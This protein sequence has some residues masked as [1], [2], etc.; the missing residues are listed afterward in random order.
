MNAAR[1]QVFASLLQARHWRWLPFLV[2]PMLL[3]P[4]CFAG[5]EGLGAGATALAVTG[6]AALQFVWWSLF[7]RLLRQNHPNT[8][9]LVPGQ[10][11]KLRECGVA[12][13]LLNA[14][15]GGLLMGAARG[16]GL[17]WFIVAAALQ[18]LFAVV[19]R[20]PQLWL[21]IWVPLG[22]IGAMRDS[23]PGLW[24]DHGL[25]AWHRAEPLSQALI[26]GL[27]MCW[28]LA[29]LMFDGGAA[30]E[31]QWRMLSA[32]RA[33]TWST[34]AAL[35]LSSRTEGACGVWL[36]R[37]FNWPFNPWL[38]HLMRSA[39]PTPDSVMARAELV[40]LRNSHWTQQLGVISVMS[41]CVMLV[42]LFLA[43][44]I[45]F[46][47]A[48]VEGMVTGLSL[49]LMN[50]CVSPVFGLSASLYASRREQALLMLL[51]GMP[52][53][54][55]LNKRLARRQLAQFVAW[56]TAGV[57]MLVLV[58]KLFGTDTP[59]YGYAPAA[60]LLAP[61]QWRDWSRQPS[62]RSRDVWLP[63]L[64]LALG[65]LMARW[66]L[67]TAHWPALDFALLCAGMA[68]ALAFWR[69]RRIARWPQAF[70][71]GRLA[72]SAS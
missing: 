30:H 44:R 21:M 46:N 31:R 36:R 11:R 41:A 50:M 27:L 70:P 55:A 3:I 47:K 54:S 62:P 17:A 23:A 52:R 37:S 25:R 39:R 12:V 68:L 14:A 20:W 33:D 24:L 35:G 8:A 10:L 2:L 43:H 9:R 16:D 26:L 34:A 5:V 51:P 45:G 69:G 7:T 48:G 19:Q 1:E 61:L 72:P 56:W 49:A 42:D 65:L 18:L 66:L 57:A 64:T 71:V 40:L 29:R 6:A 67:I 13:F 22:F 32:R 60:L 28:A 15:L 4:A 53:G 59:I 58:Q 63:M 38:A